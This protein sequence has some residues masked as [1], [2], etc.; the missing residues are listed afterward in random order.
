MS[1]LKSFD[2]SGHHAL[3]T[4][5]SRGIGKS[6]ALALA[7]AGAAVTLH[8]TKPGSVMESTLNEMKEREFRC[9]AVYGN[10][11]DPDVPGRIIPEAKE[12]LGPIDILVINASV[13]YRR[14]WESI[15]AEEAMEQLQVNLIASLQLIQGVV[16]DMQS[17]K[18]GRVLVIG[19][20]QQYLPNPKMAIYAASKSGLS[21][22]VRNL[23]KQLAPEG[24]TVNNL[25]PGVILTD[26]NQEALA[27]EAYADKVRQ[28]VP[29]RRFADPRECAAAALLLCSDAGSYINGID[30]PVDGGMHLP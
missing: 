16:S 26:R 18:W 5:S 29:A 11:A 22:L 2:L 1:I 25:A 6:I 10:L 30:L 17:R 4:G 15:S 27:D 3:V 19:S 14:E 7:E 23:A 13:Q 12:K 8:G 28:L 21:N 20:V 24:I 9:S